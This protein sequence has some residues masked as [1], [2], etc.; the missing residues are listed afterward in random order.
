MNNCNLQKEGAMYDG[1]L[2][3]LMQDVA[4][5]KATIKG[6]TDAVILVLGNHNNHITPNDNVVVWNNHEA[7]R[8]TSLPRNMAWVLSN[9]RHSHT[10]SVK[11][12]MLANKAGLSVPTYFI[13]QGVL[14]ILLGILL[15][16]IDPV[17]YAPPPPEPPSQP[18]MNTK[19]DLAI[20]KLRAK[21]LKLTLTMLDFDSASKLLESWFTREEV[22]K[23]SNR[24][25]MFELVII[26][27]IGRYNIT[28]P[29]LK[30]LMKHYRTLS[31]TPI[32][33]RCDSGKRR[34]RQGGFKRVISVPPLLW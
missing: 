17:K 25:L 13:T 22:V 28:W 29:D 3:D 33:P 23:L 4:N 1:R 14:K 32:T 20:S 6:K 11:I 31:Q 21:Q 19:V 8:A 9:K 16:E 26:F 7:E 18:T 10:A 27:D 5:H 15:E 2:R 30:R 34:N 24:E 12:K